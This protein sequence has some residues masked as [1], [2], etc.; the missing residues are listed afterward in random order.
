M[1]AHH[2]SEATLARYA[3]GTLAEALALVVATH[4]GQCRA[5]QGALA[6]FEATAGALLD[7]IDPVPLTA[8]ALQR[9]LERTGEPAPSLSPILHPELPSPLNRVRFGR[10]WPIGPGMRYR[11]L[12]SGG[13]AWG[14]LVLAQPN[15]SL[16]RHG[17]AGLELTCVLSGAFTDASGRFD[18]GDL[19][20]PDTD[21]D[22]PPTAVGPDPCLCVIASEGMHLRGLFGWLQ[23]LAGK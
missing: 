6:T 21:H 23:R 4:L 3:A 7:V 1:S 15:R 9:V 13:S 16:P 11:P 10:W 5:C 2:P 20:E 19:C 14:G 12:Q 22:I 18:P 17:H 8:G